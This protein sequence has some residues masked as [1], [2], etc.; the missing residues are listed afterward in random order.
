MTGHQQ[1]S[2][3]KR[4]D[5]EQKAEIGQVVE[6]YLKKRDTII[7]ALIAKEI[8]MIVERY[9]A[10]FSSTLLTLLTLV[11]CVVGQSRA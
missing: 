6:K 10:P 11:F 1:K 7:E 5:E 2:E 3:L 8:S 4:I 9:T